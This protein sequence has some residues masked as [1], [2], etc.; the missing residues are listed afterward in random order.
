MSDLEAAVKE[1]GK[2]PERLAKPCQSA[3]P[4]IKELH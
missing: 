2:Y 1:K 4:G 3:W